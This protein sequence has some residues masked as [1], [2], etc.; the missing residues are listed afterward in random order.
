MRRLAATLLTLA[1]CACGQG[2][3]SPSPEPELQVVVA[4]GNDRDGT[5][6]AI[7][8]CLKRAGVTSWFASCSCVPS[9]CCY[10]VNVSDRARSLAYLEKDGS[11]FGCVVKDAKPTR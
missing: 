2:T 9:A 6:A 8:T 4:C 5:N 1:M 7:E 3:A 10:Y 11:V